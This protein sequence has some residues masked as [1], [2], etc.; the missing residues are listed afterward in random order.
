[1]PRQSKGPR[2]W[3]Q[4]SRDRDDGTTERSVWII[5]D[6]TAKRSTGAGARELGKAEA[7]LADYIL[8]KNKVSRV[9]NRDPSQIQVADVITIYSDDIARHRVRPQETAARLGRLLG[10]FGGMPLSQINRQSCADYVLVRGHQAAARRELEDLRAAINHHW[11]AGLCNSVIPVVLPDRGIARE[12]WLTRLEVARLVWAAWRYREKQNF[13]STDRHTRRHIARFILVAVYTGTR[14]G[15][16]C[17]AALQPTAGRGWID[18]ENGVFYRRAAGV[19]ETKKRQTPVRLP[20]R[21]LAHVRRWK[22]CKVSLRAVVEWNGRP[23]KRINKAFR[24][25]RTDA[26]FGPD[27]TPHT[28]RHTCATWLAQ[29]GVPMWEA[30]GFLGMSVQTFEAVYGHHH[31]DHQRGAVNAFKSR[32]CRPDRL[33]VNETRLPT[34]SVVNFN[35]KH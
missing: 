19:R 28:F 32:N 5:R 4:P 31:P 16:I 30:A 35:G 26:G 11:K 2:L 21:L 8:S 7:A 3:L 13:H 14:A 24:G 9:S 25:V 6:G 27:V 1:M 15:A 17:G 18:L 10:H 34:P 20:P 22:R 29:A 33:S 23:V 12:R